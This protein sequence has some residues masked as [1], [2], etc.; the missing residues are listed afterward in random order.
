MMDNEQRNYL[1]RFQTFIV[2]LVWVF[3]VAPISKSY[4]LSALG[5]LHFILIA[6]IIIQLNSRG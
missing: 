4:T 6:E 3:M 2:L 5:C 1:I